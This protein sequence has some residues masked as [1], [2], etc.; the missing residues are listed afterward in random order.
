MKA[1]RFLMA[2]VV[3]V[4]VGGWR[5]LAAELVHPVAPNTNLTTLTEIMEIRKLSP[6]EASRGHPVHITGVVTFSDRDSYLHFMQD[7]TAGIYIDPSGIENAPI[8]R[9]GQ[10][11][12]VTGFSA[13]GDYAP[14]VQGQTI[15]VLGEDGLP[16]AESVTFRKLMTGNFDSQWVVLKGVVRNEWVETNL[17]RLALFSGDGVV[18]AFVRVG[19]HAAESGSLIDAAVAIRGVCTT[20][21]DDRRRLRGVELQVPG[22][23][24]VEVKE[25]PSE[26]PFKLRVKAVNELFQFHAEGSEQHRTH[27]CGVVTLA[28]A[29]GSFYMQ[30][31]SGGMLVQP[32]RAGFIRIGTKVNAVGFPVIQDQ[33]ARLQDALTNPLKDTRPVEAIELKADRPLEEAQ[34]ATLIRLQGEILGRFSHG[35]EELLTVRFGQ[36]I[37]DVVLGKGLG[38]DQ[39]A[40]FAPGTVVRLTG[41]FLGQFDSEGKVQAFRLM[42]RSAGDVAV[43]SRPAWWT[44]QRTLWASGGLAGILLLALGW[45]RALRRQVRQ[46]TKE[47]HE[48]IELHKRTEAKLEAEIG[49]RQRMESEVARTHQELLIASRQAGM[50]E[51]ATSVLHNVGNV[52]NSVNVSASLVAD[53]IRTSKVGNIARTAELIDE[54]ALDLPDF[55]TR[56]PKGRQL[57]QYLGRLAKHLGSEQSAILSE[58]DSL[59]KNVEH[60]K[61]I[62]VMQQNYA[63]VF[64]SS[65]PV[66]PTELVDDALR[67]H[68]GALV[69]H[70]VRVV[71]EYEENL[72][73]ITV[74]KHK[75]LQI[76]VNLISNAKKAC[77]ESPQPQKLLTVRVANGEGVLRISVID[78]GVG[79][80]AE[81][82]TRIFNH[83]FTTRKDGHGFGLHSGALAA[84]EM[85]GALV[86]QSDG[87]GKGAQFTIEL[88]V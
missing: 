73:Q 86:V 45:V 34:Q 23:Q 3:L 70:E 35:P 76:L 85:G 79:I 8:L 24:Q 13:P 31:E 81:N 6:A 26:D 47:L 71:R 27:L 38:E 12:E 49:E 66:K 15:R 52:L 29:D 54:H 2:L 67:M 44:V 74:D 30:D 72:P 58:L 59:R 50:A 87:Q 88:P 64:G 22:W 51:V 19:G 25:A 48:E 10:K 7:D 84:K 62:V 5:A 68:S 11:I 82:L 16:A 20:V 17:T 39:L 46:R 53:R 57:P 36:K 1:P 37:I 40:G 75:L 42:L 78:N 77:D 33:L 32:K 41:V 21:F 63:K 80:P 9:S 60:I 83:G 18:N 4:E 14:I 65:E 28:G 61:G 69:R 43:I 55:L 56:D